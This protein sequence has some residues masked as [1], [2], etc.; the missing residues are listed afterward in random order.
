MNILKWL[1]DNQPDR[2]YLLGTVVTVQSWL[3]KTFSLN[4]MLN[5]WI[6]AQIPQQHGKTQEW[7][8]EFYLLFA[9]TLALIAFCFATPLTEWTWLVVLAVIWPVYRI[10]EIF[11]FLVGWVFVHE[12]PLHSIQ[13]S[14]LSFFLNLFELSFLFGALEISVGAGLP[15]T[16]KSTYYFQG[17]VDIISI[18]S[19]TIQISVQGV[20]EATR[21]FISL[22][23]VLIVVGSL[24]GSMVRREVES[25]TEK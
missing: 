12:G 6:R 5:T 20:L 10:C 8:S 17:L 2:G 13:R 3:E 7:A 21:F 4:D 16:G 24:A 1:T 18:A 11:V 15:Q 22:L 9:L 14:L 25:K 19:P 23:L